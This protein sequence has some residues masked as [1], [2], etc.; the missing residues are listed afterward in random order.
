ME[1]PI[2]L[3]DKTMLEAVAQ[4]KLN[5]RSICCDELPSLRSRIPELDEEAEVEERDA[6]IARIRLWKAK[7]A[8]L[9]VAL[10]L[11]ESI[12]DIASLLGKINGHA[13]ME[14]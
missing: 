14:F 11:C 10:D 6:I 5:L 8:R 3:Q 2:E 9:L 7:E 4:A 1:L 13:E 12:E